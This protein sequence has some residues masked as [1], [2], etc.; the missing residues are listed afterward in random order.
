MTPNVES[1]IGKE[2]IKDTRALGVVV[3]NVG[4]GDAIIVR[5]PTAYSEDAVGGKKKTVCALVD[6]CNAA[7]TKR[8]LAALGTDELAFVCATHPHADHISGL[9]SV[10]AWCLKE[11]IRVKQFWDSGFRHVSKLQYDLMGLL[12]ENPSID[13]VRPTAG[14][15]CLINRV[16]VQVLSPSIVLRNRYDTFGTNIN[17]ASIVIKLEYPAADLAAPFKNIKGKAAI[18]ADISQQ[19]TLKQNIIILGGDAQFDAWSRI[20]QEFPHLVPTANRYQLIDPSKRKHK[21][22]KCQLLKV[23][24]HMSK[25]GINLEVLELLQPSFSI[26]S[27]ANQSKHGFPH[28]ITVIAAE[29]IRSKKSKDKG[30]RYTGHRDP[31]LRSGTLVALLKGDGGRPKLQALGETMSQPAPL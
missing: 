4:D 22:L 26:A 10:L 5:F 29:D 11:G 16:R 13:F 27:C 8:A 7:K 9:R 18:E 21:P 31:A 6:C 12:C 1:K 19:E 17:N 3:L 23:P 24:H 15:D 14:Y 30:I 2:L 25:H 20:T 28:E